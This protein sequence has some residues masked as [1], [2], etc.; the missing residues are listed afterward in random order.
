MAGFVNPALLWGLALLAAPI[1]IHLINLW[2]RR[3]IEWAAMEFLLESQRKSQRWIVLRQLLLLLARMTAIAAVVLVL[4]QPLLKNRL[5]ALVGAPRTHHVILLD[6][7]YSMSDR[8]AQTSAFDQAISAVRHVAQRAAGAGGSQY[9]SL[10]RFSRAGDKHSAPKPDLQAASAD[11][12]LVERLS[13]MLSKL[14]PS[15]TDAGPLAA[16]QSALQLTADQTGQSYLLYLVSD[17]RANAWRSPDDLRQALAEWNARGAE[18]HFIHCVDR[19]HENLGLTALRPLPGILA[20]GVPFFMQVTVRNFGQSVARNVSV[21]IREDQQARPAL[22]IDSIE[23]GKSETRRVL[24]N[25]PTP[26]PHAVTASLEADAVAADN[27]RAAV[28]DLPV[29]IPVL[30]VDGDPQAKDAH[31]LSLALSPGGAIR[32]GIDVRLGTPRHLIDEPLSKY[33][34]I[35]LTNVAR[36]DDSAVT[37]LEDYVRGGGGLAIFLGDAT[38]SRFVNEK[39]H[40]QG[41]GLFPLEVGAPSALFVDAAQSAPDLQITDHPIFK[42]FQGERNSFLNSVR[43][44]RFFTVARQA[45]EKAAGIHVLARLRVGAPLVVEKNFGQGR[46]I[47]FLTTA[48]PLWNNWGR[49]PSFVVTMLEMQSYLANLDEPAPTNFVGKP[50]VVEFPTARYQPRA[51]FLPPGAEE[52]IVLP[53]QMLPEQSA[54]RATLVDTATSGVY[55]A[56]LTTLDGRAETRRYAVD[57]VPEEGNLDLVSPADLAAGLRGVQFA[58]HRAGEL[59]WGERSLAG[60]NLS[61][62]LLYFLIAILIGEQFLAYRNSY[63]P[64]ATEGR[65]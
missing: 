3:R 44:E 10:L 7:S 37:A 30:V 15:Q 11:P 35:Y 5:G 40:R 25:F 51:S 56:Q 33:R 59:D 2:R 22:L 14:A 34:A 54:F 65:R 60:L 41:R 29:G 62:G 61:D 50:L 17:F 21:S 63:H 19:P 36:L 4:A 8:W 48:A 32:T 55:E 46:V 26:G 16:L 1:L 9:V 45:Q 38:D 57:V 18:I 58:A 43:V 13:D 27:L 47:A 20:A 39:L 52:P 23:P 6:D 64:K 31:F 28:V 24:V 42:V 12:T 49:N 53:A